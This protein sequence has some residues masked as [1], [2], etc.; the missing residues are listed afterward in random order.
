MARRVEIIQALMEKYPREVSLAHDLIW[1]TWN[2]DLDLLLAL[3]RSL[4][5]REKENPNDPVA[6]DSPE[7]IRKFKRTQELSPNSPWPYLGLAELYGRG[8][9]R[10]LK[11]MG[12]NIAGFYN[13]CPSSTDP[14]AQR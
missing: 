5:E 2:G 10:D 11:A 4:R 1:Y 14:N 13:L 9:T 12:E 7:A 8:K 3:Q 6:V